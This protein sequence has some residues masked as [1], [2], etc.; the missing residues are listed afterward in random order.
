MFKV[1][2]YETTEGECPVQDFIDAQDD[3]MQAR[4]YRLIELLELEGNRLRGPYSKALGDGIFELRGKSGNDITRV[5][6]FFVVGSRV[7]LTNGFVKKA[8]K[9]PKAEIDRAKMYRA[10]FLNREGV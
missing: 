1:G 6:Y 10:D 5:L 7:I 4:I 2:F 8:Q 9:T 3:R